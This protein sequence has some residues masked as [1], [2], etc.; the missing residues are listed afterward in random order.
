MLHFEDHVDPLASLSLC[1]HGAGSAAPQHRL[2]LED[3]RDFGRIRFMESYESRHSDFDFTAK[4]AA[5]LGVTQ[6]PLRI[7]S[8]AKYGAAPAVLQSR[9][10]EHACMRACLTG[11]CSAYHT[12]WHC[13][14]VLC[15]V[16]TQRLSVCSARIDG[17]PDRQQ[18]ACA[19]V[20]ARGDASINLRFPHKGYR[21]KIWDH[22]AGA[23]IVQEAGAVIS[24]ASG[25]LQTYTSC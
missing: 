17:H 16:F 11:P 1:M 25:I 8:Q 21:E 5:A 3:T 2:R 23:L 7:D 13:P 22:A 15:L 20:L 12:T 24:D 19:G 10:P 18:L 6:P 14:R 4:L 9:A